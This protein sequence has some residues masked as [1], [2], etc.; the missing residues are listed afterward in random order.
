MEEDSVGPVTSLV[1]LPA[2]DH[3]RRRLRTTFTGWSKL[4]IVTLS[5][6]FFLS[7]GRFLPF[8]LYS[9]VLWFL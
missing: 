5:S 9:S 1:D 8:L 2:L 6:S 7:K 3:C 4:G